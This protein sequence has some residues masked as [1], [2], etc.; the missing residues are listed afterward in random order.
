MTTL[1]NL[2]DIA[3]SLI[4]AQA[5]AGG[6]PPGGLLG[7]PLVFMVLMIVMMY[8]LLIRPQRKR[9][10]EHETLVKSLAVGDHVVLGGGEHGIVTSLHD[11][12]IKVKIADNVKVEY[13]RAA[14][15]T[16]TKKSDIK[17]V[18]PE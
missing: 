7:N 5:P 8:F 16:V 4:L 6:A 18:T 17:D 2:A 1:A 9:Q 14:V 15:A 3:S 13:E 11:R 12:T 10:K